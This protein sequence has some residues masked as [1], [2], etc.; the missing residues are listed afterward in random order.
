MA[1]ASHTHDGEHSPI[2]IAVSG[3]SGRIG[4]L[5]L[6]L[7]AED[8]ELL[9]AQALVSGA[10]D[11]AGKPAT[12]LAATFTEGAPVVSGAGLESGADVMI[13]FSTPTATMERAEQAVVHGTA[14]VIGTTGLSTEQLA[15]LREISE[16]IPVLV[17]H[18]FSLG[19]NLLCRIA[20][21]VARALGE[22]FD[23]EVVES[24]HNRKVDAPS[25][26]ALGIA[27][28]IAAAL[29]RDVA[30]DLRC[31]REGRDARRTK[32]EIGVHSLRMGNVVGEH[33]AHFASDYE[34]VELT[35]RAQSRDVFAA[36]A[37]R[38][39]KWIAGREAGWY[40]MD[41]VLFRRGE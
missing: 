20:A 23:V 7:A 2:G 40:T 12:E 35:H 33:T 34:R 11:A 8:D 5:L 14:L 1:A 38:A 15:R 36:G 30:K 32:R 41:D 19:V 13:D 29:D 18:N 28:A 25:G 17:A 6:A 27:G 21:D 9:I 26:T 16:D 31:G 39:A 3:A 24:H 4:R 10:S 37:L 22:D